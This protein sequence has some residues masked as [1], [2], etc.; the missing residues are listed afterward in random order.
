MVSALD[1]GLSGPG[2]SLPRGTVLC[3]WATPLLSYIVPLHPGVNLVPRVVV[4]VIDKGNAGSGNEIA[5]V[6][7]GYQ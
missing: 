2:L 6:Y 7:N 5:K 1:S 3:S 4:T